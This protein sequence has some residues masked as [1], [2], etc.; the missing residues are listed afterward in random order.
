MGSLRFQI[1]FNF[2][3]WTPEIPFAESFTVRIYEGQC[4]AYGSSKNRFMSEKYS[5]LYFIWQG[6]SNR[7]IS[8]VLNRFKNYGYI[9]AIGNRGIFAISWSEWLKGIWV[10]LHLQINRSTTFFQ[11]VPFLSHSLQ[12]AIPFTTSALSTGLCKIPS[13]WCAINFCFNFPTY[14]T[15]IV[16]AK[17]NHFGPISLVRTINI[18][19][20]TF[21]KCFFAGRQGRKI[22]NYP[23]NIDCILGQCYSKQINDYWF[24]FD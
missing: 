20:L 12:S 11:N 22:Y 5:D 10:H 16:C 21:S 18:W 24:D 4:V 1:C 6:D 14:F 23:S 2:R 13:I 9:A 3:F 19:V 17:L 7:T 8:Q 15:P